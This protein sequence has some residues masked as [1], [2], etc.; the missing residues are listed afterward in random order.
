MGISELEQYFSVIVLDCT[1]W[2]MPGALLTRGAAPQVSAN[3]QKIDSLHQLKSYLGKVHGGYAV[4]YV[5]QFSPAAVLMFNELKRHHLELIVVDSG[6]YPAPDLIVRPRGVVQ[7]IFDAIRHGGLMLHINAIL[8]QALLR[9]LP[10]QRPDYALVSGNSWQSDARFRAAKNIIPAHSFDYET[11]LKTSSEARLFSDDFA[12]YLDEDITGHEDNSEL[13]FSEP[14]TALNFYPALLEY[15]ESFEQK[16]GLRV[17]VAGYPSASGK[18]REHLFGGRPV[19]YGKTALLVRDAKLV[20]A[21]AST[22][23]SYAVLARCPL[24]FLTSKEI[25]Q[26]WYQVWIE[27]PQKLLNAP[28]V[29]IDSAGSIDDGCCIHESDKDGYEN[30]MYSYIKTAD[31]PAKSLWEIFSSIVSLPC[32]GK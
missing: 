25:R 1:A 10:D 21:H 11:S 7:K 28:M 26:S 2:L 8:I 20:M 9:F 12:V 32:C 14:A 31:S 29:D 5:G 22:A 27:A 6:A 23:I 17:I 13:G 3:V 4:D 24:I 15:F 19:I 18:V 30:Y 16:T